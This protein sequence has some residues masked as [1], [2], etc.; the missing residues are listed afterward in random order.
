MQASFVALLVALLVAVVASIPSTCNSGTCTTTANC[1]NGQCCGGICSFSNATA[2]SGQACGGCTTCS[3][4][5]VCSSNV[6]NSTSC[7]ATQVEGCPCT[8]TCSAGLTCINST[9]YKTNLAQGDLCLQSSQCGYAG[10]TQMVCTAGSC[11][12][13]PCNATK[14]ITTMCYG[15]NVSC[16]YIAGC[17]S[18]LYCNGTGLSSTCSAPPAPTPPPNVADGGACTASSD[19]TA[20]SSCVSGTCTAAYSAAAGAAC[21]TTSF[22]APT[23]TVCQDDLVCFGSSSTATTGVCT[24]PTY[25]GPVGNPASA[26]V[27]PTCNSD[28]STCQ[29]NATGSTASNSV[30]CVQTSNFCNSQR[31]AVADCIMTSC[32]GPGSTYGQLSF[33]TAWGSPSS[34]IFNNCKDKLVAWKCCQVCGGSSSN[35]NPIAGL[36]C[37]ASSN[38]YA[39]PSLVCSGA[40]SYTAGSC[41]STPPS[42]GT[43][44]TTSGSPAPG[45]TSGSP[46][47]GT[48]GGSPT[49][50]T[51][52]G[53]PTTGTTSGSPT[54]STTSG[55]PT[56]S[57]TSTTSGSV[58]L[59]YG[60]AFL[61]ALFVCLLL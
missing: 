53:S 58:S 34:C 11:T 42:S 60:L 31:K 49:T 33:F 4:G 36:T 40:C 7:T 43:P 54:P 13:P 38:S 46:T 28:T 6:C 41:P 1:D 2:N 25:C 5:L 9:C 44:G 37:G 50:G 51:T 35:V 14:A 45:T 59:A 26:P 52:S 23:F 22:T 27:G 12:V 32:G 3:S 10:T 24:K 19:C 47:T 16:Q 15:Q 21:L 55:T 57:P 20:S 29:C 39:A 18:T 48:T 56:P 8:T 61:V 17:P 30:V